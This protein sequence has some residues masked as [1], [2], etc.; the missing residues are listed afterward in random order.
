MNR[1]SVHLP[2]R[3]S[4]VVSSVPTGP[5]QVPTA[6]GGRPDEGEPAFPVPQLPENQSG[7]VLPRRLRYKPRPR[8]WLESRALRLGAIC[9]VLAL[10]GVTI[11]AI[12]R[13]QTGTEGFLIGLVVA[14]L[15]V[16]LVLGAYLWVDRVDPEPLRNLLFCFGWGACAATLIAILANSWTT[17]LLV[18]HNAGGGE[19]L[20]ASVV[21]PIIEESCKGAALLLLFLFRRRELDGIVDGIVY[22]G[23]TATGF[24]FTENILYIG[25]TV[26]EEHTDGGGIGVTVFTFLLREVM[27][28]FAHPL[29]T[30]MTGIGFGLAALARRKWLRVL[31]P[32]GG[33]LCAIAMHAA[34]NGSSDFG[35]GGFLLVYLCFMLPVFCGM[36][37]LVLWARRDELKVVAKQLGVYAW[38]GWITAPEPLVLSSM[39]TRRQSRELAR[40]TRGPL[41][42]RAMREYQ[43][44]ATSLAFLRQK[45]DR[46]LT[47][48]SD[49][50]EREQ[51]L[52][53]HLWKRKDQLA[54]VF[55]QVGAREWYRRHNPAA[56]WQAAGHP[57]AGPA[58][59]QGPAAAMP[60][61]A[62]IQPA[63]G[64]PYGATAAAPYGA[65][66]AAPYGAP[67]RRVGMPPYGA[68]ARPSAVPYGTP[69]PGPTAAATPYDGFA[70]GAYTPAPQG[71]GRPQHAGAWA[72][73]NSAQ[74]P[75]ARPPAGGP[76]APP[77]P[78]RPGAGT[79]AAAPT[80]EAAAPGE[81]VPGTSA[82]SEPQ[83]EPSAPSDQADQTA[84]RTGPQ[85]EQAPA[86]APAPTPAPSADAA[87][88]E[89]PPP[90]GPGSADP[91]D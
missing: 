16:P 44:F 53:H 19:L 35:I 43:G 27:S 8:A 59:A 1:L 72:H 46:G 38:A 49:F 12:V 17:D 4:Q 18:S 82:D 7:F 60:Y 30:G 22:A 14:V 85:V 9:T 76:Y 24:A 86:P 74:Q 31:A 91:E 10:C 79:A 71:A 56:A 69:M 63:G 5:Q 62:P 41:G 87:S 34:W 66:A 88:A 68:A 3:Y 51:E 80:G 90:A 13:Q 15:P 28:P 29:F 32:L 50:T 48:G 67:V 26:L 73:V 57:G 45:A 37:W 20:G 23:F 78:A 64:A 6:G 83:A 21:A 39:A 2:D 25:R 36:V 58:W 89:A 11:L 42:E 40:Y 81:P 70:P 55:A 54:E 75:S 77:Q 52:L 65:P 61:G 33:W 84:A 47:R